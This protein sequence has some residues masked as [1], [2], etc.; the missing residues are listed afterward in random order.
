MD[1]STDFIREKLL[2]IRRRL[3]DLSKRNRLLNYRHHKSG[4]VRVVD[5]Q[6]RQV[7]D[8]LIK[9][10]RPMVFVPLEP[11]DKTEEDS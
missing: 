3:L 9:S 1:S 6:P 4:A 10:A 5:E 11:P 7:Y 8:Y 2:E